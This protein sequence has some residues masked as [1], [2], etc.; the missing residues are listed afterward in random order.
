ME[1]N[2]QITKEVVAA[3]QTEGISCYVVG[4]YVRDYLLGVE[5]KDID[6]EL[7]GAEIDQALSIINEVT[8]AKLFGTFGVI[9]LENVNTEFALA[10]TETKAGSLHTDF[11]V[12]F[13]AD[14]DLKLAASRRDFTVNSIMYDLQNDVLIDNYNG[15]ADL[16]AGIIRHVSPAFSED[17]L[18]VLRAFKFATRY[19]FTIDE[20]T[21]N[22]CYQ[23]ADQL[24]YLPTVR[25]ENELAQLFKTSNFVAVSEMLTKVIGTAFNS[26]YQLFQFESES[27]II[28][29]VLFFRQFEQFKTVIN[30]CFEKKKTKKD[31]IFLIE[32]YDRIVNYRNLAA[33]QKY[34]LLAAIK[35][36]C[37]E[38]FVLNPDLQ[39]IY[40][41]YL[42]LITEYNGNYFIKQGINGKQIAS[43]QAKLI[44]E[45]LDEL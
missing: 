19:N 13:I 24:Q 41:Q 32:N 34:N 44:G 10:R 2:C 38:A 29:R 1:L 25:I 12:K 26:Q 23:I 27:P 5:S 20:K 35:F 28:Y 42:Q 15:Q 4:G 36:V 9:S 22:L 8:P 6:I 45:H 21:L 18:R 31:L 33:V 7:H 11:E 40:C 30:N 14:G 17:P 39:S 3:L 37:E 16:A 43:A